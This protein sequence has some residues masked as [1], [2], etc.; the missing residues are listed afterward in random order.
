M[1]RVASIS[2]ASGK[3]MMLLI[4][5]YERI[6]EGRSDSTMLYIKHLPDFPF[7]MT[8]NLRK[9]FDKMFGKVVGLRAGYGGHICAE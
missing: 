7:R 3:R 2:G 5:E 9:D 1:S 6:S 4:G 8:A